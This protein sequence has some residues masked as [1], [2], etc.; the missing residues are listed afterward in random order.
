MLYPRMRLIISATI[1]G[2]MQGG[3]ELS[4]SL[5]PLDTLSKKKKRLHGMV[6]AMY[7]VTFEER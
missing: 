4:P 6:S 5:D 1:E 2:K 7:H 3:Q